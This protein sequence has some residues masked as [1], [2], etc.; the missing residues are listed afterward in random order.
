MGISHTVN[1][2]IAAYKDHLRISQHGIVHKTDDIDCLSKH[3]DLP[4]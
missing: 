3:S 4:T 1:T 2:N